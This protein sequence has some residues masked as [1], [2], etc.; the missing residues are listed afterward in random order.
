M[1]TL[2]NFTELVTFGTIGIFT[3]KIQLNRKKFVKFDIL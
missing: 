3:G 2:S 1:V